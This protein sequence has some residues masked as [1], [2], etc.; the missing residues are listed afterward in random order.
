[1]NTRNVNNWVKSRLK[2]YSSRK[3]I[4]FF[5]SLHKT[6]DL[7]SAW[8][9]QWEDHHEDVVEYFKNRKELLVFDIEKDKGEKIANFLPELSFKS[10][11]FPK[12][13]ASAN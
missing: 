11:A 5:Q 13:S 7:E 8:I 6:K 9:K 1:M 3:T 4:E 2:H 12:I 10:T